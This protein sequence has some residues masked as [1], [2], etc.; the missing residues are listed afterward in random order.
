[1]VVGAV[2]VPA[3]LGPRGSAQAGQGQ[4]VGLLVLRD[5]GLRVPLLA[6]LVSGGSH[7]TIM[8]D[9][10]GEGPSVGS[11]GLSGLDEKSGGMGHERAFGL[12]GL[13]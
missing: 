6:W 4:I 8:P 1:M 10:E 5:F 2:P 3:G 9:R 11:V 13:V 7:A 12:D